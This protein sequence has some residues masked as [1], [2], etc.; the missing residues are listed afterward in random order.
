MNISLQFFNNKET[1]LKTYRTST[2][3]RS[4]HD[5]HRTST[6]IYQL[7]K[8]LRKVQQNFKEDAS[9]GIKPPLKDKSKQP[10]NSRYPKWEHFSRI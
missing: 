2:R 9:G 4:I 10:A 8:T 3:Y 7:I 1:S 6:I 5:R